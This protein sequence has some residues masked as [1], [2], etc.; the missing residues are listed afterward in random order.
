M[1]LTGS[2]SISSETMNDYDYTAADDFMRNFGL[3]ILMMKIFVLT[4]AVIL[5]KKINVNC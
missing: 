2:G 4:L 3:V 1:V 5:I